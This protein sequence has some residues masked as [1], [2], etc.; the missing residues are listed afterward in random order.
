[1]TL[2][3]RATLGRQRSLLGF[4]PSIGVFEGVQ[5]LCAVHSRLT[6]T[7]VQRAMYADEP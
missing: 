7:A 2:I 6:P 5:R 3:K 1:M 4:E